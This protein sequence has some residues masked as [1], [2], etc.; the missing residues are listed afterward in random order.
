LILGGPEWRRNQKR[1]NEEIE[2]KELK[3]KPQLKKKTK[4][5]PKTTV[6]VPPQPSA[7]TAPLQP[8]ARPPFPFHRSQAT[9]LSPDSITPITR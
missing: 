2:N 4:A 8:K 6:P 3:S 9:S 7:S 5:K 1:R